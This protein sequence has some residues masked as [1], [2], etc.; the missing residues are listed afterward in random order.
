MEMCSMT[1]ETATYEE[2]DILHWCAEY[3]GHIQ[4]I[5][6]RSVTFVDAAGYMPDWARGIGM[7]QS[8]IICELAD[9]PHYSHTLSDRYWCAQ[10]DNH[11]QD[12][13]ANW[14]DITGYT[15][16]WAGQMSANQAMSICDNRAKLFDDNPRYAYWCDQYVGH[17]EYEHCDC[18]DGG[19]DE[20]RSEYELCGCD[21]MDYDRL[22][23]PIEK[24]TPDWVGQ[25]SIK[26]VDAICRQDLDAIPYCDSMQ[27]QKAVCIHDGRISFDD[28]D[29]YWCDAYLHSL[30]LGYYVDPAEPDCHRCHPLSHSPPSPGTDAMCSII[31]RW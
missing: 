29:G 18:Y 20:R 2:S 16:N 19:E 11:L 4:D 28:Q 9:S 26:Q 10:Y 7:H 3:L 8:R 25:K 15:P 12:A 6:D 21:W 5:G 14:A 31:N 23:E 27:D 1:C 17:L 22:S 24:Q 13:G 30:S